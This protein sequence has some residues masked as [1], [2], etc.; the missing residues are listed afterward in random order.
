ME[1]VA[2]S[3]FVFPVE[4]S[5]P[6]GNEVSVPLVPG[7]MLSRPITDLTPGIVLLE[8]SCGVADERLNDGA[9]VATSASP[10][11]M[12]SKPPDRSDRRT[13]SLRVFGALEVNC[14]LLVFIPLFLLRSVF[15]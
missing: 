11:P 8:E 9:A 3:A 4:N 13:G 14:T 15:C 6:V 10:T 5:S 2:M 7:L 12:T 1:D